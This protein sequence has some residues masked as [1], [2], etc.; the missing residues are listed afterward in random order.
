[1]GPPRL[2][3]LVRCTVL[4]TLA[5]GCVA[6]P[7]PSVTLPERRSSLE[8]LLAERPVADASLIRSDE[9]AR[10]TRLSVHLVQAR[11]P[12]RPHRH[13]HHDLVV[14][15]VRGRGILHLADRPHPLAAG[16]LAVV[17]RGVPHWFEPQ[18]R[19]P[20]VAVVTFSPP[21]DGAD[22]EPVAEGR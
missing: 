7:G 2:P 11:G 19:R 12:E 22:S 15:V 13:V 20:A 21:F 18:G 10:T 14:M 3:A 6:G 4:M 1:M 8:A 5:L 16:D 17:P 9:V